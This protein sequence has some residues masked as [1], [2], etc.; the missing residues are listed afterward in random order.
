MECPFC[1]FPQSSQAAH[2]TKTPM[3]LRFL[4]M[5]ASLAGL[6]SWGFGF[7]S[8][9]LSTHFHKYDDVCWGR[10]GDQIEA[11]R[12]VDVG[13]S[14]RRNNKE[15]GPSRPNPLG[16]WGFR[17][18]SLSFVVNDATASPPPLFATSPR[19]PHPQTL[20]YLWKGVL[21]FQR[22][23]AAAS[24]SF[25]P[26]FTDVT[27]VS[28]IHFRH[29]NSPT[30]FKYMVETMGSG[31]AFLDY[32]R[33]GYLDI[34][35]VNGGRVPG[36]E[37]GPSPDHTLYR[38]QRD[39]TF[40]EVGKQSGIEP[41]RAYGQGVAVADYD[42]D[43][44]DDL[45]ITNFNG[46]NLLYHN[47]GDG[48]FLEVARKAGVASVGRWSTGAAFLDYDKD[49][50]LDLY[51]ARY[52]NNSFENNSRCGSL[53]DDSLHTYCTPEIYEGI[54][55]LLY[56]NNG[57]GT[58]SDV[59]DSSGLSHFAGKGLGVITFDYNQDGW[60]DIYVAN[61]TDPNFLFE[62]ESDGT[63]KEV[64]LARGVAVG[65]LN[66]DGLP[67]L[68]VSNFDFEYLI[69]Y[70]QLSGG[71]FED[72]SSLAGVEIPSSPYVGFGLGFFDFDNDSDLDLFLANG[73]VYD[74]AHRVH[75]GSS[76]QQPKLL[77]ENY[78]GRFSEV[79][80]RPGH[81]LIQPQVSRGTCFGDYD[82]DGDLDVL[83]SNCGG[84]PMLLRNDGGNQN[85]WLSLQLVGTESNR[86][87]IG[88]RIRL[89]LDNLPLE[90]QVSGGGSYLSAS[91]YRAHFGLGNRNV[92][93]R[94]E[95]FWPSGA[96]DVRTEISS[97][98]F[99]TIREGEKKGNEET[100]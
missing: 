93:R 41:N 49:G 82:N 76:Y 14:A 90:A 15:M 58:F 21:S 77:F 35:L 16:G 84:S 74:N 91:D 50:H 75:P 56:R 34:F 85:N 19:K 18:I 45:F 61:D 6:L 7:F 55:D 87:G 99:L 48:R 10:D 96:V 42:N 33:D 54:P 62:N 65:D 30:P 86:N 8:F 20:S 53:V 78:K 57:D 60:T 79:A 73:H 28:G 39:G 47:Q 68:A 12:R 24:D 89:T 81:A 11:R 80:A 9:G 5:V 43:G 88:A 4:V 32:N 23:A 31:C 69:L 36:G 92:V 66:W 71:F 40:E 37:K 64:A 63:W 38:N 94:R 67:D 2:R 26:V 3:N 22:P 17:A 72:A 59:T 52:V 44:F 100:P 83:V 95:V 1:D 13:T 70:R 98:Q 27:A 97:R 46:P 25:K 51:V 29:V